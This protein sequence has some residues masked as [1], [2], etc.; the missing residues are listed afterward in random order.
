MSWF[1]SLAGTLFGNSSNGKGV[2]Q[3]AVDTYERFD[4]SAVKLH[5]MSL[6][7]QTAGDASQDSARKM[8]VAPS[9]D[10]WFDILIDGLN[11]SVRP[12]FTLWAF[13]T[14]VGWWDTTAHWN[15]IP[16]MVWNIIWT[17]ITFWFGSRIL[18]KDLPSL[19]KRLKG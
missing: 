1:T 8:I 9:H 3:T 19:V 7:D 17:I 10:S 4:P 18:F 6:E 14:L 15:E 12:G 16:P 5:E 11:R 2:V 13:G